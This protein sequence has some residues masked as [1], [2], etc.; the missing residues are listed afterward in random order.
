[1]EAVKLDEQ[2]VRIPLYMGIVLWEQLQQQLHLI[3]HAAPAADGANSRTWHIG[4]DNT[5][6]LCHEAYAV[7]GVVG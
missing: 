5:V 7:M 2:G 3:L 4:S 1:M 6:N